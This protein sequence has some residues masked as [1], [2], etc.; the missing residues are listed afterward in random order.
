MQ[1]ALRPYATAGVALVGASV[2]AVSP[3]TVTP[4]AAQEVREAAVQLSA[5][6]NPIDA[7]EPVFQAAV[8]DFQALAQ[9]IGANPAP[10]LQAILAN[11]P[12][13][14]AALPGNALAQILEIPQIPGQLP[15]QIGDSLGGV[16][17]LVG[18]IQTFLQDVITAVVSADPDAGGVLIPQ[19]QQIAMALQEGDLGLA[20]GDLSVLPLAPILNPLLLNFMLLPQIAGVFQQQLANI[21]ELL[22]IASG[23]LTTA[24]QVVSVFA[25]DP[26]ALLTVGI[27]PLLGVNGVATAFGNALSGLV[28]GVQ[29]G[30]PQAALN[31]VVTQAAAAA[32]AI[33]DAV[34]NPDF[35][36]LPGLQKL[37]EEIGT[38]IGTPLAISDAAKALPSATAKS[39]TLAAPLEKAPASD[40]GTTS[41]VAASGSGAVSATDPGTTTK[42]GGET[43]P[44]DNKGDVEGGNLFTPGSTK[45]GRHRATDG[46]SFGQELRDAASKTIKG[47]TGLGGG[48]SETSTAGASA[49]ESGS[50]SS[51]SGSSSGGDRG[52]K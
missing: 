32:Q 17:S 27:G 33:V 43:T 22:P 1:I 16:L 52:S 4:T 25:N 38:A 49:G 20:F 23:P 45:G 3:V 8:A 19:L 12:G 41:G 24:Q 51:G 18:P 5:L 15:G 47:L 11:L 48:K 30:D 31:A 14:I 21:Q 46:A 28:Q 6:T 29:S 35:G 42:A 39:V 10:I 13:N 37:G 50:G 26:T 9:Q 40:P 2:I 44:T 7:F 36:L 34:A